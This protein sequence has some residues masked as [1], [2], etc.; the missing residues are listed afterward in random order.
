MTAVAFFQ[1]LLVMAGKVAVFHIDLSPIDFFPGRIRMRGVA[2][3]TVRHVLGLFLIMRYELMRIDQAAV[4][5]ESRLFYRQLV[6]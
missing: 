5:F 4:G 2:V 3:E 6:K 1:V